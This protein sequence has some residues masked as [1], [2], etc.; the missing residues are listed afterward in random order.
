M[1]CLLKGAALFNLKKINEARNVFLKMFETDRW[2][3]ESYMFLAMIAQYGGD[4]D[5]AIRR[6]KEAIYINPSSWLAHYHLA[7]VY[8]NTGDL[9]L[10]QKEYLAVT[11]ILQSES[12][13]GQ[14]TKDSNLA[15]ELFAISFNTYDILHLCKHN[16]EKINKALG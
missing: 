11:R 13:Q 3:E 8:H 6:F 15:A 2:S 7:K 1:A 16:I 10:A 5:E 4:N 12:Q 9:Q 14:I